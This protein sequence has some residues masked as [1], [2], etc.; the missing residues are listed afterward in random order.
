MNVRRLMCGWRPDA[1]SQGRSCAKPAAAAPVLQPP[2][3]SARSDQ[4]LQ[5]LPRHLGQAR[6]AII[7]NNGNQLADIAQALRRHHSELR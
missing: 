1:D 2:S 5:H 6:I 3:R 7:A 4:H